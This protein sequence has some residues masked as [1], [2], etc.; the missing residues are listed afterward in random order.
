V[1]SWK[2]MDLTSSQGLTTNTK[3]PCTM[4]L[5][6]RIGHPQKP[7]TSRTVCSQPLTLRRLSVSRDLWG[8]NGGLHLLFLGLVLDRRG[9]PLAL[10][11]ARAWEGRFLEEAQDKILLQP[12]HTTP[13]MGPIQSLWPWC[14]SW[15]WSRI[16]SL[17]GKI[18]TARSIFPVSSPP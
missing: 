11:H 14:T 3:D 13:E 12:R 18:R 15:R 7:P 9:G 1:R 5:P 17:R 16:P 10:G 6:D 8:C 2:I 4:I